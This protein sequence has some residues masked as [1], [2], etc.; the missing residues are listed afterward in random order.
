MKLRDE[1]AKV[2]ATNAPAPKKAEIDAK[3]GKPK[4][5]SPAEAAPKM[6]E[7]FAL[8]TS[9][10]TALPALKSV[11][12]KFESS[13]AGYDANLILGQLYYERDSSADAAVQAAGYF[14]RAADQKLDSA[15]TS[16]ALSLYAYA[17]EATGKKD[18]ALAQVDAALGLAAKSG[19][20]IDLLEH[21][22]RLLHEKGDTTK[23]VASVE[24]LLKAYPNTEAGRWAEQRKAEW[25]PA[26]A[27]PAAAPAGVKK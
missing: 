3:T 18:E 23:A 10:P 12:E 27:A 7:H 9:L 14:K 5:V 21:Q 20:E 8:A 6:P 13:S 2:T 19:I 15:R 16:V 25:A 17:L 1:L 22:A 4:S 26:S 11:G 24:R